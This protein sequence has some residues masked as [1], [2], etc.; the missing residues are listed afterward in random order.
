MIHTSIHYPIMSIVWNNLDLIIMKK[1][2][3]IT[4]IVISSCSVNLGQHSKLCFVTIS[5]TVYT[6][7]LFMYPAS[8]IPYLKQD[9]KNITIFLTPK[10]TPKNDQEWSEMIRS[11]QEWSGL[12]GNDQDMS[13]LVRNDQDWSGMIRIG[14]EWSEL[15][16]NDQGW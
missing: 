8:P 7:S 1:G 2:Y 12:V 14:Q 13:R 15:V 4:P 9:C 5:L 16:R 10:M 3:N 6:L 11:G